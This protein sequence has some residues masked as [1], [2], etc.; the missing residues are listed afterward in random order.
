MLEIKNELEKRINL[1]DISKFYWYAV[2]QEWDIKKI[3]LATNILKEYKTNDEG[4]NYEKFFRKKVNE[5]NEQNESLNKLNHRCTN[6]AIYLNFTSDG[7]GYKDKKITPIFEKILLLSN[8]NFNNIESYYEIYE[9]QVEKMYF[10]FKFVEK[11]TDEKFVVHPLFIL[12]KILLLVGEYD[13]VRII[14]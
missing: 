7:V 11:K 6:T 3:C 1:E 10:D 14:V 8:G 5:Y 12:Y 9:T 13:K 4:L 2:K